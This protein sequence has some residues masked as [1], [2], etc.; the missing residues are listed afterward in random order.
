MRKHFIAL[1][2]LLA[3]SSFSIAQFSSEIVSLNGYELCKGI[4]PHHWAHIAVVSGPPI[5]LPP[6]T[7]IT[8]TWMAKNPFGSWVWFTSSSTRAVPIPWQGNYYVQ[9]R[10]EY[11]RRGR[12]SP[13]AVFWSNVITI[14]GINCDK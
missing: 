11:I 1:A 13:F 3:F 2:F 14:R 10:V 7:Y 9:V 6:D 5:P 12:R 8:Y 4:G